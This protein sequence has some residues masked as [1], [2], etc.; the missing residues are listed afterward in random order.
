MGKDNG[1]FKRKALW[2]MEKSDQVLKIENL[3]FESVVLSD[4]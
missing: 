4:S 3:F 1:R 2:G